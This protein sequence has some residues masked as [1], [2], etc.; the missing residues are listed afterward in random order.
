MRIAFSAL[1][2]LLCLNIC[3]QRMKPD[4]VWHDTKRNYYYMGIQANLLLQQ[5]ISFNSNSSINS[6]PYLF[7]YAVNDP[8]RGGGFA[9]GTGLSVNQSSTNDGVASVTIQNINV[10]IRLG[11]EKKYMQRSKFIPFWGVDMGM[12]GVNN[13]ISSTLNQSFNNS[14]TTI[15]TTK[16]FFGPSFR[17]GLYYAI[18]RHILMGTEFFFNA[19]V[20]WT[21]TSTN[22]GGVRTSGTNV[23]PFNIGFQAPTALFLIFRY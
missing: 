17:S 4:S 18:T 12:G 23:V 3:A 16:Y 15:E 13:K 6:N 19:Q 8:D 5:F 2:I 9:L 11:Y 14:T 10:S 7:C 20:A 1:L 21:E 22:S